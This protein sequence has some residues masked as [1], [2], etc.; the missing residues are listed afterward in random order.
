[1]FRKVKDLF[2]KK[3]SPLVEEIGF[4]DIPA[5]I[6]DHEQAWEAEFVQAANVSRKKILSTRDSLE[7]AVRR[8]SE[9]KRDAAFH[10][11]LEKIVQNSLPQFE[12]AVLFALGRP[13]PE[14]A[15]EFYQACT[16]S[17]KGCVKGLAGP[18]RYLRN[19]FPEEMKEIRAIIDDFGKEVNLFTPVVAQ[20]RAR[21]EKVRL[22]LEA[23]SR[24]C[25]MDAALERLSREIPG[26]KEEIVYL[27]SRRDEKQATIESCDRRLR[28]DPAFREASAIVERSKKELSEIA[29]KLQGTSSTLVHVMR[30]AE[31][32]AHRSDTERLARDLRRVIDLVSSREVPAAAD[33]EREVGAILPLFS[34][35]IA[36]GEVQLKNQEE[37]DLFSSPEKI[38]G[39][40]SKMIQEN[41]R[42][43]EMATMAE[44]RL[45]SDPIRMQRENAEEELRSIHSELKEKE[46]HLQELIGK[47]KEMRDEYPRLS[48][49]LEAQLS[50]LLGG[51]WHIAKV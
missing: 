16:E 43:R 10:P 50:S 47:E 15:D 4:A 13:L 27:T 7:A 38:P 48:L 17:L 20:S 12:K 26:I 35:M 31:K 33:I 34:R 51:N 21:R 8:L 28:D 32:I 45:A 42:A 37:R 46:R 14:D 19:V 23:H 49:Q 40:L 25:E 2:G 6:S 9:S 41:E 36:S 29:R 39:I 24:A 11:K 1:M 18:G 5:I 22:I 44:A 30:K 3:E